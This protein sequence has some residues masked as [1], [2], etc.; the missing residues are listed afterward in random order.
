MKPSELRELSDD[1]LA[2]K[3]KDLAEE[4]FKLKFQH[5]IRP[6]ENTSNLHELKKDLARVKTIINERSVSK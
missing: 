5:G 1:A 2:A 4:R 3:A 6:L